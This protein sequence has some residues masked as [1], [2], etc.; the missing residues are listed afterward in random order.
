MASRMLLMLGV[1]IFGQAATASAGDNQKLQENSTAAAAGKTPAS[2]CGCLNW[3]SVYY[4]YK[5]FC[6]RGN[7]L[8][9]FTKH[10][11]PGAYAATEPITG[12]LHKVCY[13][14]F[15]NLNKGVCVNYDLY[16]FPAKEKS[17]AQWCYVPNDCNDLNGGA[18]ATNG[19][20]FAQSSW[21]N[22]QSDTFQA[23]KFC[24]AEDPTDTE[25]IRLKP[26]SEVVTIGEDNDVPLSRMLRAAYPVV[27]ISW[28]HAHYWY[29]AL[30][31]NYQVGRTIEQ[32]VDLIHPLNEWVCLSEFGISQE[33]KLRIGVEVTWRLLGKM[34]GA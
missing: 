13:D 29:E 5:A 19:Q 28:G 1:A 24:N 12:V 10:G 15:M 33:E 31:R 7:E 26:V 17:N 14:F 34:L 27:N 16:P 3:A 9:F 6:G 30:N 8:Y 4:Q 2:N 21:H 18:F 23:W 20:G 11:F 32:M 25:A 22:L